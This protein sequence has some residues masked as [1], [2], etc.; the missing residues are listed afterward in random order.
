MKNLLTLR[1]TLAT[2]MLLGLVAGVGAQAIGPLQGEVFVGHPLE[3]SVPVTLA[4]GSRDECVSAEVFY[5]DSRVRAGDV[6]TRWVGLGD[7]RR[8]RIATDT[9][10]DEPV[11]TVAVRA[12]CTGTMTR[13][14]TLLADL[15]PAR[16][17]V[18]SPGPV[19]AGPG[20]LM[21]MALPAQLVGPAAPVPLALKVRTPTEA[22]PDTVV[23]PP[24]PRVKRT[25]E[26]AAPWL[27][28]EMWDPADLPVASSPL[29]RVTSTLTEPGQD[30][31]RR[32]AAAM[33]WQALNADPHDLMRANARLQQLESELDQLRQSASQ[34]RAEL[35]LLRQRV[36]GTRA[37][38]TGQVAQL[39][40]VLL[41][42][43]GGAAGFLWWR[44]LRGAGGHWS[45]NSLDA[46]LDSAAP[47]SDPAPVE[48]SAAAPEAAAEVAPGSAPHPEPARPHGSAPVAPSQ[49]TGARA[50]PLTP[51]E[52]EPPPALGLPPR[53]TVMRVETLAAT[54]EE[55]EFLLSLE[56]TDDAIDVLKTYV[57]D[58]AAPAPLAYLE[59]MRLYTGDSAAQAAVRKRY[60]EVFG[61]PAPSQGQVSITRGLESQPDLA[62]RVVRAW[63]SPEVLDLIELSLF[64]V[65]VPDKMY[66]LEA[67]RDLLCLYDLA[68]A[69][70]R[71]SGTLPA[72]ADEV[73][74]APWATAESP[75]QARIAA[76]KA[77]EVSGGHAFALD[78]DLSAPP[79]GLLEPASHTSVAES[80]SPPLKTGIDSTGPAP[81]SASDD[82]S[83]EAFDAAVGTERQRPTRF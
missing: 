9:P 1:V 26:A 40:A 72:L 77:A 71:D 14:Y 39:I 19:R 63:G 68:M 61:V 18:A 67:G 50:E 70:A 2:S 43:A 74:L 41:A 10:V 24:P 7:E 80:D 52:L 15:P 13:S 82:P 31:G 58:S 28:L 44:N 60:E 34:T 62:A 57:D 55:V 65:A 21:T 59:L 22:R 11:V 3:L 53:E 64:T 36:D 78:L 73:P 79:V 23:R 66:T 33:L 48:R 83:F 46:V 20:G 51:P 4:E 75:A 69:L 45:G 5:G 35:T 25:R 12:G 16:Q 38:L 37:G 47:R 56:L 49:P 81:L 42:V 54:F 6:R 30:V 27:R 8:L 17:Q 76:E 32:A 29:L